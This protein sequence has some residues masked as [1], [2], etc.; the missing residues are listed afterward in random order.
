VRRL[1]VSLCAGLA[2]L[3]PA[4][5]FADQAIAELGL[6]APVAGYGGWKA[7]SSYDF[8][9]QRYTL[10]LRAPDDTVKAAPL[11]PSSKPFDMALG[12]DGHGDVVAIYKRCSGSDCDVRRLY[13]ATGRDQAINSV[14]SPSYDESTPAIWKSNVVFTRRVKGC[15]VP[16]VKNLSSS[17]GS[18]RLL[19]SKC[20]QTAAG[21]VSIRGTRIF[22]SSVDRTQTDARGAGRKVSEVRKYSATDSGSK[23]LLSQSF[24]EESNLYG[25]LAQD[26]NYLYTV[27]Y[28]VHPT[29][30]FVR[31]RTGGGAAEEVPA[32]RALTGDFAKPTDHESLYVEGQGDVT[33][34]DGS[35]LVPCR[36]VLAPAVPFGGV[37]R[38]LTPT[39][40]V[41]YQGTPRRGQPLTFTGRLTRTVLAG[42]NIVSTDPLSGVTVELYHRSSPGFPETFTATGLRGVT[43]ADGNYTITV[44]A[45]GADP[46]YTAVA[47]TPDVPTWAGRGTVGSVSG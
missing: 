19:K 9:T 41:A 2:L 26:A 36:L 33:D 39:L 20:L 31:V 23:V 4:P 17:K 22:I 8:S 37:Q 24:G 43:D 1:A 11:T 3:S 47:S 45:V 34:C 32:A 27:H 35:T 15:D 10:M 14:S 21:D 18:R 46:Y 40:T 6:D 28:G 30:A 16:Y 13:V 44:P 38:A 29:D 12:P 42:S 5:A 25:Q 7:W